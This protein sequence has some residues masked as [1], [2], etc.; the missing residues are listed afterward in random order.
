MEWRQGPGSLHQHQGYESLLWRGRNIGPGGGW[1]VA[2]HGWD[3]RSHFGGHSFVP[4]SWSGSF[5]FQICVSKQCALHQGDWHF[6]GFSPCSAS[7]WIS[8]WGTCRWLRLGVGLTFTSCLLLQN[9]HVFSHSFED[10]VEEFDALPW[11]TQFHGFSY[12]VEDP[13]SFIYPVGTFTVIFEARIFFP[14]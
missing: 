7:R 2:K 6:P 14:P 13:E 11:A 12:L 9:K 10:T 5:H 8:H 1:Y 4:K 3:Q